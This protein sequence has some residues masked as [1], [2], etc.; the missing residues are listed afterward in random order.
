MK[1][2]LPSLVKQAVKGV[3]KPKAKH[4][5]PPS[6]L[7]SEISKGSSPCKWRHKTKGHK[8][9]AKCKKKRPLRPLRRCMRCAAP[10]PVPLLLCQHPSL[11]RRRRS[12]LDMTMKHYTKDHLFSSDF[13]SR[14]MS[15]AATCLH[16]N[17]EPGTSAP[18]C[19]IRIL[20]LLSL[21][22]IIYFYKHL[23]SQPQSLFYTPSRGSWIPSG[24]TQPAT[25][26]A[27]A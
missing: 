19:P 9:K 25:S 23:L 15:K 7:L 14:M 4:T 26:R 6:P 27:P 1:T 2:Q 10:A 20:S 17:R 3:C 18:P 22:I 8:K 16:F 5:H 11:R 24:R 21:L 13:C 12:C